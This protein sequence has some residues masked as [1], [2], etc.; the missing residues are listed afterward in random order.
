MRPKSSLARLMTSYQLNRVAAVACRTCHERDLGGVSA[1]EHHGD[2][3]RL[4]LIDFGPIVVLPGDV[5]LVD[6]FSQ[7]TTI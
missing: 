1:N 3:G 6:R 2:I 4:K 5:G 7:A